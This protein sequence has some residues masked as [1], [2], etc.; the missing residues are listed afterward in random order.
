MIW[1][2]SEALE[3][4]QLVPKFTHAGGRQWSSDEVKYTELLVNVST[5]VRKRCPPTLSCT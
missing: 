3:G 5:V 4:L 2:R 1:G